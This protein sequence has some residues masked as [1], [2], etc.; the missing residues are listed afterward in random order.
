[1]PLTKFSRSFLHLQFPF[2]MTFYRSR[3]IW[4]RTDSRIHAAHTL[5]PFIFLSYLHLNMLTVHHGTL[6]NQ[7]QVYTLSLVCL[8]RVNA[9]TCF[10]LYSS[11]FKRLCTVAIWC[12]CVRRMCIV[13]VL[14]TQLHQIAT[15]QSL[16]K[17]GD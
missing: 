6:M 3:C 5:G 16:L 12:N 10:G 2:A 9:S 14:P 1:L 17:M 7:H 13:Y 4:V 8:L 15:V 11:I